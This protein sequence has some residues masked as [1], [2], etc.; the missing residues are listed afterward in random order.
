MTRL[1]AQLVPAAIAVATGIASWELVRQL[2]G[3]RE[4]WDDPVYWQLGYPLLIV[5]AFVLLLATVKDGVPNLFPLGLVTFA[6]L[7]LPCAAAA[8]AGKWLGGRLLG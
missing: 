8:Y 6:I 5:A 2:G 1:G 3:R 7:A 4:A